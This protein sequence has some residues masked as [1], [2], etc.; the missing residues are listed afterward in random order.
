MFGL[1]RYS[2][3]GA[4]M[5][6]SRF[7]SGMG[8]GSCQQFYVS[9]QLHLTPVQE[10]AEH[11]GRWVFSGMMA[12]GLGPMLAASLQMLDTRRGFAPD[13]IPVGFAQLIVVLGAIAAIMLYHP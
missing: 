7:V 4:A 11:T 6:I 2:G 8:S 10:R 12:L 5:M 3:L 1:Q 9:A 13:F